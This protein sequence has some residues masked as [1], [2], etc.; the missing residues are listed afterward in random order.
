M[1]RK[2]ANKTQDG[3]PLR[4]YKN[5]WTVERTISWF[6]NFRR[7]TI[8]YEKTSVLFQ[9]FLHFACSMLLLKQVLG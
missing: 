5:R 9:G 2:P 4:R 7:L 3:R 1:N 6:Q 8:R